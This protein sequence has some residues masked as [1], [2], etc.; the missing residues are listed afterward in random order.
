MLILLLLSLLLYLQD[1]YTYDVL[2]ALYM[3]FRYAL[4]R[5]FFILGAGELAR[6][7]SMLAARLDSC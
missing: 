1:T 6:L 2:V 5:I 3:S 7:D 4:T